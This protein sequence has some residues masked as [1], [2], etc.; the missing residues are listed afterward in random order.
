[1]MTL[2]CT[3]IAQFYPI[4]LDGIDPFRPEVWLLLCS[5][6]GDDDVVAR[7]L[8]GIDTTGNASFFYFFARRM[9]RYVVSLMLMLLMWLYRYA[10]RTKGYIEVYP[11]IDA[12][13]LT[14]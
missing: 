13:Q 2:L 14:T 12:D 11:W 6:R 1:M 3:V 8:R 9:E 4:K 7:D 5:R 10:I